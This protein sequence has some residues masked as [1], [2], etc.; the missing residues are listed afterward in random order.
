MKIKDKQID[1][2]C[3]MKNIYH[4][5]SE[6]INANKSRMKQKQFILTTKSSKNTE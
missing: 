4:S 3:F 2:C 5:I 6:I 1:I